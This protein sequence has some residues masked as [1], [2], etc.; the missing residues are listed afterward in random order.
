MAIVVA[1]ES[2]ITKYAKENKIEVED[3][4][5]APGFKKQVQ[6]EM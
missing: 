6:E 4:C 1:D 3:A 2:E 5:K